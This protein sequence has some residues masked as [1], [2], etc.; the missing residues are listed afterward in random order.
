MALV[1]LTD[2]GAIGAIREAFPADVVGGGADMLPANDD[3]RLL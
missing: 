2:P 3:V 1:I